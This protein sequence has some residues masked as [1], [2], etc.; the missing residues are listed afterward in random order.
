LEDA[1]LG[2][3]DATVFLAPDAVFFA[4]PEE[5]DAAALLGGMAPVRDVGALRFEFES[6]VG[7]WLG[8][9]TEA[10]LFDLAVAAVVG[11]ILLEAD[12]GVGAAVVL[13]G[14][15]VCLVKVLLLSAVEDAVDDGID[16]VV[17]DEVMLP[18]LMLGWIRRLPLG[19]GGSTVAFGV[20]TCSWGFLVFVMAFRLLLLGVS[21][22]GEADTPDLT[23]FFCFT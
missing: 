22:V 5:A 11:A 15:E 20:G 1:D 17:V 6:V 4:K 16:G 12:D 7:V 23:R 10:D 18:L 9:E 3:A 2:A 21:N 14:R 13:E 19:C 8:T